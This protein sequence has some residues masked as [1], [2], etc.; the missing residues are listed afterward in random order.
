MRVAAEL[1]ELND[2]DV[3]EVHST[4]PAFAADIGAWCNS[5]G[6]RLLGLVS[7]N[8]LY[9]ATIAKGKPIAEKLE[10]SKTNKNKTIVVF[11][12]DFDK[13]VASFVIANGAAAMGSNV[14]MFFT[15]WGINALRKNSNVNVKKNFIEK[16]FSLMMT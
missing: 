6:N 14:T 8:G 10:P 5:T 11:S 4:D 2:G 16:M 7:E 15:F 13:L 3:I 1:K 12:S 9:K